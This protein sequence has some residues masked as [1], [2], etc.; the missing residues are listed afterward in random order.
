MLGAGDSQLASECVV[1]TKTDHVRN[2]LPREKE[3]SSSDGK[4]L[5][6]GPGLPPVLLSRIL[7][8]CSQ[9]S[10]KGLHSKVIRASSGKLVLDIFY[11]RTTRPSHGDANILQ[12]ITPNARVKLYNRGIY[13]M[14]ER[15]CVITVSDR[16]PWKKKQ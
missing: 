13:I 6:D 5:E 16:L 11:P 4:R 12:H 2:R 14:V 8:P 3:Y 1:D 7:N 9:C 15:S 10:M